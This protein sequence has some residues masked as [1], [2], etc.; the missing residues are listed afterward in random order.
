MWFCLTGETAAV[1]FGSKCGGTKAG[2]IALGLLTL[3]A[4]RA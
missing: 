2:G 1:A 3:K 4:G